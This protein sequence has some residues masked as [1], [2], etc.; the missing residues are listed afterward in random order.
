MQPTWNRLY[1]CHTIGNEG[2]VQI[3]VVATGVTKGQGNKGLSGEVVR[4]VAGGLH[5]E[6]H[7]TDQTQKLRLRLPDAVGLRAPWSSRGAECA[8]KQWAALQR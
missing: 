3:R 4:S 1:V 7:R 5:A 6:Q 8:G 2:A